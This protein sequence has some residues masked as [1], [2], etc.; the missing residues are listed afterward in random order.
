[1]STSLPEAG[2]AS[3]HAPAAVS[4]LFGVHAHQPVGNFPAVIDD[5]VA[6]CYRPFLETLSDYPA[7][8]FA[9]HVS[10][11][12][13]GD[14]DERHPDVVER[15]AAMVARG[16]V[17]LFGA[18]DCEPVLAAIPERDR[19]AQL[20]AM[21]D[22]LARRFGVRPAGAWLTERVWES[23]VV[24]SLVASGVRYVLVDDYH[25]L[26]AGCPADRLDGHYAT[27]E[28]G[29]RV[30]VF[31]ISEAL[32]YRLPFSPAADAVA[33][34][35]SL[36]GPRPRAAVYFDDIE[37]FG[38]WPETHEWVYGRGWLRQFVESVLAS[39]R[40]ASVPYAHWHATQPARGL[41]YLPT[42][43]Y[44]E[45]NEWSLPADAAERFAALA[46]RERD[47]GRFEH[48]KPFVRGGI[49]RNFLSRYPESNWLHKRVLQLSGR[50]AGLADDDP[51]RA[52]LQALLHR[53]QANDAY[54]HGLFGGLYLPHLR[55][56]VW[57]SACELEAALDA[58]APRPAVQRADVDLD[59]HDELLLH[60]AGCQAAIRLD[61]LAAVHELLAYRL[62][63]NFADTLAR[64]AE[65]YHRRI[66][67]QG[68]APGA[69]AGDGIASAHDRVEFKHPVDAQ[70]LVADPLPR[71]CLLDAL[72]D[73]DGA[74]RP[75]DA[76]A[77]V[78]LPAQGGAAGIRF[79]ADAGGGRI[80]KSVA[81]LDG[82]LRVRWHCAG[83]AGR[84]LRTRLN[85]AMP[86]CDG[87]GGRYV[88]EDGTIPAGFGQSPALPV[89]RRLTL[90]DRELD[91]WL[92]LDCSP[93]AAMSAAPHH[94][95]SLSEGGFEKIMQAAVVDLE[96]EL[97]SDDAT[98]E[99]SL[100]PDR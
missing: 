68:D 39:P 45:M 2:T 19:R 16:Q 22:R 80:A 55:R 15:L 3:G 63:H 27:E 96:F 14:L 18:G 91:G 36:A 89:A 59:G 79:E 67:E 25:F 95:V 64:R 50:L 33:H 28:D 9:L 65:A 24:P 21:S 78:A 6:R 42:T 23:G 8:R 10:G 41:V 32:R 12:L 92:R 81:V 26:C 58:I 69:H 7:F 38:I 73:A 13:L 97:E 57:R 43:S 60:D 20:A 53:A 72:V 82:A 94:T 34:L 11:W 52:P 93:A 70:D 100:T 87:F 29:Q 49:W 71:A 46:Q 66:R 99:L 54:W 48:S 77:P 88:L 83:L 51:R 76:Y 56:A 62:G 5:A 40:I 86:S 90:D 74:A 30:D 37:K 31:A 85:L 44:I 61:G 4:L 47:A 84:R 98:I 17:E 35:E 75:I 1:M